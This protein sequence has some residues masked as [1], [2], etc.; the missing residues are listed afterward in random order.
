M[1]KTNNRKVVMPLRMVMMIKERR[2]TSY[3]GAHDHDDDEEEDEDEEDADDGDDDSLSNHHLLRAQ[4][5]PP[6]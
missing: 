4:T 1:S 6:R 5:V 3:D 2:I